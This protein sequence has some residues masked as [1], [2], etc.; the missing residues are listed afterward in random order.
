MGVFLLGGAQQRFAALPWKQ[1]DSPSAPRRTEVG[2]R[3]E[4]L[5]ICRVL[6]QSQQ[7]PT[8]RPQGPLSV[9]GRFIGQR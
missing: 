9:L 5:D 7:E 8:D 4:L 3:S 6:Q 1:V 2:K